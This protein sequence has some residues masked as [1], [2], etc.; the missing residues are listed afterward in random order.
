MKERGSSTAGEAYDEG[1]KKKKVQLMFDRE[2]FL[3]G[4]SF[5]QLAT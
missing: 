3:F 1:L 4:V 5:T 2:L